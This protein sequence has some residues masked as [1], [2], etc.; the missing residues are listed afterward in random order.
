MIF[1]AMMAGAGALYFVKRVSGRVGKNQAL[2]RVTVEIAPPGTLTGSKKSDLERKV[3]RNLVIAAGTLGAAAA[4][5]VYAPVALLA[6]PGIAILA[7]PIYQGA[8]RSLKRGE[9]KIEAVDSVGITLLVATGH[10]FACSLG[11]LAYF[12]GKK[13]LLATEDHSTRKYVGAL[14]DQP[15]SAWVLLNG[16]EA[17]VPVGQVQRG[18]VI[19][20]RAGEAIPLD[21]RIRRG[22]PAIDERMLTG[23]SQPV[24]K[25]PGDRCFASTLVLAGYAL[26]EVE[27]SGADSVAA[28]IAQALHKTI[29]FKET[30]VSRG[31]TIADQSALPLLV[32][33]GVS[34]PFVGLIGGATILCAGFGYSVR[35]VSPIL[36]LN[37]LGIA[38]QDGIL[39][40]D[41]R[42][43]E[44]LSE[45]DTVVFD[46]TGTL[47]LD[48]P[49]VAAVHTV[50]GVAEDELLG[51]AAAAEYRQ[52]HPVARGI[53]REAQDRRL[54]VPGIEEDAQYQV[55]YGVR[56]TTLQGQVV[57]AGSSRFLA[58]AGIAIPPEARGLEDSLQDGCSVLYVA[59]DHRLYGTV[60]LRPAIRAEAKAVIDEL[61][62][63]GIAVAIISG[64]RQR[65]TRLLAEQLGIGSYYAEVLPEDKANLIAKL[66]AEG[67][68]VCFVGDGIN[69]AIALKKADVSISLRGA[70]TI[71]T[72][73]AQIVLLNGSLHRLPSLFGFGK[74]F[75][76]HMDVNVATSLVP[77]AV[78][79]LGVFFFGFGIPAA[80]IV[81]QTGLA[82]A[83]CSSM[84][85]LLSH[86]KNGAG[87]GESAVP[88]ASDELVSGR[89]VGL[90]SNAI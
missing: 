31:Q 11:A 85:P 38:Y 69:D 50:D 19:V 30:M 75:Q 49:R 23:E 48:Q 86:R 90:T 60:D 46:K 57:H 84:Y 28:Q 66:Q 1:V 83:F 24:E 29:D 36:V 51:F 47:T 34:I 16:V 6:L 9:V 40:K 44:R 41:G 62:A 56:V 13:L 55:G 35:L 10:F 70:S 58:T 59:V 71:A 32:L 20:V 42:S 65:P 67:K 63:Q 77:S 14:I 3:D 73:T 18:D 61:K 52:N 76:R 43:I 37:Y 80:V 22:Y 39:I 5:T 82:V 45:I 89:E 72:D 79:I 8:Y 15:Q 25:G 53:L 68:R 2:S 21:G 26:V 81:T 87:A 64:D 17:E 4:A 74:R 88:V 33:S 27:K 78:T 12:C 54:D 7:T